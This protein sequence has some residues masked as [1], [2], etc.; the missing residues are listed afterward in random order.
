MSL[1]TV[2][3]TENAEGEERILR[4]SQTLNAINLNAIIA[5]V[6]SKPPRVR[7]RRARKTEERPMEP[8]FTPFKERQR[9][10]AK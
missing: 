10:E 8:E 7:N 6:N 9:D 1:Y 2:T 4:Y 5:A 3:I